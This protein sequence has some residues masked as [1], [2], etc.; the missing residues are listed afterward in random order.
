M[1]D[2]TANHK[3]DLSPKEKLAPKYIYINLAEKLAA[4]LYTMPQSAD[5]LDLDN[6]SS[7]PDPSPHTIVVTLRNNDKYKPKWYDPDS[8]DVS[9]WS[10]RT[11]LISATKNGCTLTAEQISDNRG[12]LLDEFLT[13]HLTP[14][15]KRQT[16]LIWERAGLAEGAF[17]YRAFTTDD[18]ERLIKYR[19]LNI[20]PR[21]NWANFETQ[22]QFESD[23]SQVKKYSRKKDIGYSENILR[24]KIAHPLLY[25]M[26]I[27]LGSE[28]VI[29]NAIFYLPED[30]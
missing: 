5:P 20:N 4:A 2:G 18:M 28:Y 25:R 12:R 30:L 10:I 3:D 24:W 26:A 6:I 16:L 11:P 9:D 7:K 13:A 19:Y 14:D 8:F 22:A 17:L 15:Q 21:D 1:N 27:S 23:N 29:P